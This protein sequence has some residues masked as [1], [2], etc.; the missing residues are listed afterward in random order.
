MKLTLEDVLSKMN[1]TKEDFEVIVQEVSRQFSEESD[2]TRI[3]PSSLNE[4]EINVL[5][6][7]IKFNINKKNNLSA[8]SEYLSLRIKLDIIK[9][10]IT[11]KGCGEGV[12]HCAAKCGVSASSGINQGQVI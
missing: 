4:D 6:E 1:M 3:S 7:E 11:T 5:I 9:N 10:G 2:D 12:K 8:L